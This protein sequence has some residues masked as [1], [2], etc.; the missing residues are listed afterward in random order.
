MHLKVLNV[1]IFPKILQDCCNNSVY[2]SILVLM[3]QRRQ[4]FTIRR[5]I[6]E[7]LCISVAPPHNSYPK[8]DGM[9]GRMSRQTDE[10]WRQM[11]G[12]EGESRG[13]LQALASLQRQSFFAPASDYLQ[14][15][16]D[17]GEKASVCI[18]RSSFSLFSEL[19]NHTLT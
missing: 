16:R 18:L 9:D 15:S 1:Y 5:L 11:K 10:R 17:L 12:F 2:K 8:T 14:H 3:Q 13:S 7:L 6:T 19:S 4:F